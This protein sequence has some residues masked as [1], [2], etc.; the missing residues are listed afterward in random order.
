MAKDVE[1]GKAMVKACQDAKVQLGVGYHLRW[2]RGHRK[3]VEAV[4]AGEFG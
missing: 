4:R 3:I 2:H 1:G